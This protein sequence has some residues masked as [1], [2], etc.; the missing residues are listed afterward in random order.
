M[1]KSKTLSQPPE[2]MTLREASDFWDE[3]SFL[4]YDDIEEVE[5][6]VALRG[7]KHYFA[8]DRELAKRIHAIARTRGISVETLVNLWLTDKL[9]EAA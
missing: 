5:F 7:E 3:H 2:E 1:Q 9:K 8:V 4:D 6:D